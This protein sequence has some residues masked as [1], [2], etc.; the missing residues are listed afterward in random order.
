MDKQEFATKI[1][2]LSTTLETLRDRINNEE[3][4]KNSL[5]MPFFVALGYNVFDPMEFRTEFT[6]DVG[7]KKGER[8]DY[9]I[10][11]DEDIAMLIEAKE[12]N[13]DLNNHSSQL[14]RYFN[15]TE[16]RFAILTNGAEYRFFTDL[17]KPNIM[18]ANP[19]LTINLESVKDSQINELFKFVKENFDSEKIAST[20]SDLKYVSQIAEF[21]TKTIADPSDEFVRLMLNAIGFEGQKNARIIEDFRPMVS[22]GVQTLINERVN[23][24]LSSAL[25][26]TKSADEPE[27]TVISVSDEDTPDATVSEIVTTSEELEV[28]TIVKAILKDTITPDRVFYRDNTAYFNVLVDD[29]IRR[30]VLRAYFN[31]VRSWVVINDGNNTKLEF[32]NPVDLLNYSAQI[33]EVANQFK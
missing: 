8:V 31:S 2:T 10:H 29:N 20:A 11:L 14:H 19:F 25:N 18:D 3:Q 16:A 4:T 32:S 13:A 15:V 28:Y 23:D 1:K 7:I 30:W 27:K 9:A 17:D 12:L 22:R 5:I 26:S 33:V 24:R 6:A 21:F